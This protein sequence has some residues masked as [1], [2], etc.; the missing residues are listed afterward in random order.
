MIQIILALLLNF[1]ISVNDGSGGPITVIDA[2]TGETYSIG[3]SV[4][5]GNGVIKGGGLLFYL[6]R[7][8]DGTYYLV[9]R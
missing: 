9:R 2:L 8:T 5:L 4:G 7:N 6:H 3:G 1:G